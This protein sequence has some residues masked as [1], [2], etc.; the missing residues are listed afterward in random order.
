MKTDEIVIWLREEQS[1][2]QKE[3]KKRITKQRRGIYD[4][5]GVWIS[6]CCACSYRFATPFH[7]RD[8]GTCSKCG[9]LSYRAMR[10]KEYDDEEAQKST[11]PSKTKEA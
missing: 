1:K 6:V 11:K 2:L 8:N 9:K 4:F 10:T 5:R 3:F 7:I